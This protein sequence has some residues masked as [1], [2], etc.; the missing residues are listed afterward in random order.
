MMI[1]RVPNLLT[2]SQLADARAFAEKS[3]FVD[4][5]ATNRGSRVK[6]NE[7]VDQSDAE[8]S[9]VGSMIV[10]ALMSNGQVAKT[11]FPK[12]IPGP[13]FSRYQPG[14]YY[15][16]HMDQAIMNTKPSPLRTDMSTTVFLS[17]KDEYEGGELELWLGSEQVFIKMNAGDAVIYPTGI[18]HQVRPVT[19]G[20][21]YAAVTWIQSHIPEQKH[22]Q[23][24]SHYH[25]LMEHMGSKADETDVLLME[26]V[27][28]GLYRMWMDM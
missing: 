20:T 6:K 8:Q 14:M 10:Q 24:L 15:G 3:N 2:E 1:V 28:T 17:A 21:R 16:L 5:S 25:Q 4:G 12:A 19:R 23:V 11:A 9:E 26:S 13:T 7:Q 27:R 18:I 22:R